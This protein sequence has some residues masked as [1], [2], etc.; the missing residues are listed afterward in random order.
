MAMMAS[1]SVSANTAIQ[2]RIRSYY[3]I[4]LIGRTGQGKSSLG[5]KLLQFTTY[6]Q[7]RWQETTSFSPPPFY[8]RT[9]DDVDDNQRMFAVTKQCELS[10][11]ETTMVRVLDTPGL[12]NANDVSADIFSTNI[13][14]FR[15]MVFNQL[16]HQIAAKRLLYFLPIRGVPCKADGAMQEELKV[17]YHFFGPAVFDHMVLVATQDKEYQQYKFSDEHCGKIK[18]VLNAAIVT[19][20]NNEYTSTPPVIYIGI[21]DS[22]EAVLAKIKSAP[23]LADSENDFMPAFRDDVCARCSCQIRYNVNPIGTRIPVGIVREG[24][25][26]LLKYDESKC[27]PCFVPRYNSLEKIAG[28]IVHVVTLGIPFVIARAIGSTT[29]PGF[30]NSSEICPN[31]KLSPGFPPCYPVFKEYEGTKVTHSNELDQN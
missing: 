19:V 15:G 25:G 24:D 28:G 30:T 3:D 8:F 2:P 27:H 7:K 12:C 11:N 26:D 4:I 9:A 10:T 14:I 5:N 31:C 20:T 6:E 1:P 13:Q 23:V 29:W 17:M 21:S 18:M 22:E 16:M